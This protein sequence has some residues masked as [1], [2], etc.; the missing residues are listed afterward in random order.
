M[1]LALTAA[2]LILLTAITW[3]AIVP[4]H[5]WRGANNRACRGAATRITATTIGV[6]IFG[7]AQRGILFNSAHKYLSSRCCS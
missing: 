4:P 1:A 7:F 6:L 5:L 2:L 3:T